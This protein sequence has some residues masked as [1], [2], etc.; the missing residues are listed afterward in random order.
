PE[1]NWRRDKKN[2]GGTVL[3]MGTYATQFASLVFKDLKPVK[4]L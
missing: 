2:G 3:D 4:I 1:D